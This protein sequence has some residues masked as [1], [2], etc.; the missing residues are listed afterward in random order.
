MDR[1]LPLVSAVALME[2]GVCVVAVDQFQ[3]CAKFKLSIVLEAEAAVS[4][5]KADEELAVAQ[6]ITPE[7][8][9]CRT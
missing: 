2:R 1:A 5:D 9:V 4:P 6:E 7:P 3:V 8:S